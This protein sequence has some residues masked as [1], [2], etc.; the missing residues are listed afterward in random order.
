MFAAGLSSKDAVVFKGGPTDEGWRRMG[1]NPGQVAIHNR[2]ADFMAGPGGMAEL[3]KTNPDYAQ[4][5][6]DTHDWMV[7]NGWT[8]EA[9]FGAEGEKWRQRRG[10]KPRSKRKQKEW[11]D[12]LRRMIDAGVF[13]PAVLDGRCH[14]W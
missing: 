6:N 10:Y 7:R 12:Q 13:G 2:C 5:I 9:W 14:E 8:V 11:R 1:E 4:Y 3:A